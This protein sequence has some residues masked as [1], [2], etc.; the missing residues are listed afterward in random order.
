MSSAEFASGSGN[1]SGWLDCTKFTTLSVPNFRRHLWSAF[2]FF[3]L[4]KYCSESSLYLKL[5]D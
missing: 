4:T 5:K 2:F 3:F 1:G